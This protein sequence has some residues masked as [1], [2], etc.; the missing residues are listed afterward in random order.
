MVPELETTRLSLRQRAAAEIDDYVAMDADLE[1]RRYIT[2]DFR[3]NFDPAAYRAALAER[4]ARDFGPGFGH[5]TIRSRYAPHRFLGMATLM[6]VE[7]QGPEIEIGWRLPRS[8]W[9]QGHASEAARRVL[10]H[11]FETLA[12]DEVVALIDPDNVRSVAVATK[13]GL[14]RAGRR[15]AY[16]TE[17]DLYRRRRN[18]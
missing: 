7:G 17:F 1:V 5:W 10:V 14:S 16:G 9:G 15:A 6:P 4:M 3:D 13:L 11:G 12:L 18:A 8:A 2:P